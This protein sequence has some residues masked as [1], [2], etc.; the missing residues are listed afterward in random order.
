[1]LKIPFWDAPCYKVSGT[2]LIRWTQRHQVLQTVDGI[3]SLGGSWNSG[4]WILRRTEFFGLLVKGGGAKAFLSLVK[5]NST[6]IID[7]RDFRRA[8]KGENASLK[9]A[10]SSLL[11]NRSI[12]WKWKCLRRE[13]IENNQNVLSPLNTCGCFEN[14]RHV[15]FFPVLFWSISMYVTWNLTTNN[16]N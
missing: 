3:I 12:L 5:Q 13:Q 9:Y 15:H 16:S 11:Y 8:E 2:Y 10:D 7:Y 6:A 1:M 4:I 14:V